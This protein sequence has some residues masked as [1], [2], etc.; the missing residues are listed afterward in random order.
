MNASQTITQRIVA[1]LKAWTNRT[2]VQY[3]DYVYSHA[4]RKSLSIST[5]NRSKD[6]SRGSKNVL[7]MNDS[8][9]SRN[10]DTII[11]ELGGFRKL[12]LFSLTDSDL[13][14]QPSTTTIDDVN[15]HLPSRCVSSDGP[16]VV[17]FMSNVTQNLCDLVVIFGGMKRSENTYSQDFDQILAQ[18]IYDFAKREVII[19]LLPLQLN[20]ERSTYSI[21]A[22]GDGE[23]NISGF[24]FTDDEVWNVD[25]VPKE[26]NV[27]IHNEWRSNP[28][29]HSQRTGFRKLINYLRSDQRRDRIC[30]VPHI[31]LLDPTIQDAVYVFI[32]PKTGDNEELQFKIQQLGWRSLGGVKMSNYLYHVWEYPLRNLRV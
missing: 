10:R 30:T 27:W 26:M 23:V 5:V 29:Q 8:E 2:K 13:T 19:D 7:E 4:M 22:R 1:K 14:H 21:A 6:T 18:I 11:D 25:G 3:G 15:V 24:I 20:I 16:E 12:L 17:P 9:L 32:E 31:K 28:G